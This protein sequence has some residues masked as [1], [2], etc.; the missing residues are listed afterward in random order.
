MSLAIVSVLMGAIVFLIQKIVNIIDTLLF[1]DFFRRWTLKIDEYEDKVDTFKNTMLRQAVRISRLYTDL[2]SNSIAHATLLSQLE[3]NVELANSWNVIANNIEGL[4][5]II[6]E[7]I[8]DL[9]NY[10]QL[11]YDYLTIETDKE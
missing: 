1:G 3:T 9:E 2:T 6:E 7:L 8:I 5:D 10:D 4:M 11:W